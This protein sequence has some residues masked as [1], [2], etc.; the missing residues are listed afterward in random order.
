ML[1]V[2]DQW[3]TSDEVTVKAS[4]LHDAARLLVF[5]LAAMGVPFGTFIFW[6]LTYK[7]FI[8]LLPFVDYNTW[9]LWEEKLNVLVPAELPKRCKVARDFRSAV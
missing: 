6:H 7:W 2:L 3:L 5:S 4:V 8:D 9:A 1:R